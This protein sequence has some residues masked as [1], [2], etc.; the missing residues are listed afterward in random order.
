MHSLRLK[1]LEAKLAKGDIIL[2][3][4]AHETKLTSLFRRLLS[5]H[6][7][8]AFTIWKS[9]IHETSKSASKHDLRPALH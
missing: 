1:S 9:R 4:D 5:R 3:K 8:T 7:Q 2:A 6:L